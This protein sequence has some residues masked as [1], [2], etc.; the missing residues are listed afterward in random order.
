MKTLTILT[1][2]IFTLGLGAAQA[3]TK[4]YTPE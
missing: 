2:G 3:D 4:D 1:V